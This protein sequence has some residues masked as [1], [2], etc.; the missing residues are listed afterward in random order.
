MGFFPINIVPIF[1]AEGI[2][3]AMGIGCDGISAFDRDVRGEDGVEVINDAL[4]DNSFI[5]KVKIV[6]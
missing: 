2:K 4:F 5:I 6:L 3:P 1:P